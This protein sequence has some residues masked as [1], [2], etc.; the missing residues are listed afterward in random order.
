VITV[1]ST[2]TEATIVSKQDWTIERNEIA[3]WLARH[4]EVGS[5][6]FKTRELARSFV[7]RHKKMAAEEETQQQE[8][9]S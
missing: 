6:A 7:A 9:V 3:G 1:R 4:P 5:F 8:A 2:T